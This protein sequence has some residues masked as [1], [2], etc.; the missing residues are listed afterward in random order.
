M[1]QPELTTKGLRIALMAG[2]TVIILAG[3]KAAAAIVVPFLLALF[4]A[5][6]LHP[7]VKALT[8]LRVPRVLAVTLIVLAIILLLTLLLGVLG[9]S[10]TDFSR[11]LPQ[12]RG[13]LV[14]RLAELQSVAERVNLSF[15]P[16]DLASY[17]DPGVLMNMATRLVTHLSGAMSSLFLLLMTVVFMLFEAPHLPEKLRQALAG[18]GAGMDSIKKALRG[19]THYLALKTAISVLTG[20]VV[21]LMLY[22]LGIRFA[23]MWGVLAFILNYIPNIGSVLAAIPPVIQTLLFGS[24]GDAMVV[25]AGYAIVNMVL[26]NMLEPKVMG[27]GLGLSTLVVF[28]SLIF[29]G[30]LLGPV[31]MLLSVPLTIVAKILLEMTPVG[32]RFAVLLGDGKD[33]GIQK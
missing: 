29:W 3:I 27:R 28:L 25:T 32:H 12:Y 5:I 8:R 17:F 21:W 30:W 26:G 2:M 31:G 13:M 19:V 15:S 18:S 23:L 22:L 7:V 11:T 24:F 9:A 33:A 1:L 14:A 10:V 4:I 20:F 16:E 6:I